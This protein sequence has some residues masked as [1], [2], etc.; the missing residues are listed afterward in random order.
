M[1]P[2][3]VRKWLSALE[4][5]RL[6]WLSIPAPVALG[7]VPPSG[8]LGL[9]FASFAQKQRSFSV[10]NVVSPLGLLTRSKSFRTLCHILYIGPKEAL[11][12]LLLGDGDRWTNILIKGG[13]LAIAINLTETFCTIDLNPH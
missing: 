10:K 11:K 3:I 7:P 8:I 1:N 4:F 12:G 2:P 6:D 13:T 9:L 5:Y